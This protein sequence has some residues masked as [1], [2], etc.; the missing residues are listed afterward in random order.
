MTEVCV[1]ERSLDDG[2]VMIYKDF[3]K[4]VRMA[5]DP[6]R[7]SEAAALSLLCLYL[8][9]LADAMRIVHRADR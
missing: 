7:L 6:H 2:V 4:R 1:E 9:Y 8:P 3:G 5:H